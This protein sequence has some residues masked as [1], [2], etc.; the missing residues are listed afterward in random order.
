[1]TPEIIRDLITV[2]DRTK[3]QLEAALK[4]MEAAGGVSLTEAA[5]TLKTDRVDLIARLEREGWIYRSSRSGAWLGYKQREDAGLLLHR[6]VR[7][8]QPD[9]PDKIFTQVLITPKG[10]A[11]LAAPAAMTAADAATAS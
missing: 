2:L 4:L 8:P 1:M 7:R 11:R 3:G 6:N 10:L 9:G 5:K